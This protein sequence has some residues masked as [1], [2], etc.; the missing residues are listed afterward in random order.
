VRSGCFCNPDVREIALGFAEEDLAECF[1]DKQ[2][3]TYDQFLQVIE[4][5]KQGALR[6]SAG[7]VTKSNISSNMLERKEEGEVTNEQ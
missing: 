2:R 7:L 5:R 1:K 6:I 3:M 4:G